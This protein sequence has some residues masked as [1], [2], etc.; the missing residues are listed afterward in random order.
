MLRYGQL[1]SG[2]AINVIEPPEKGGTLHRTCVR[3]DAEG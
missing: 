1:G 2:I 3:I